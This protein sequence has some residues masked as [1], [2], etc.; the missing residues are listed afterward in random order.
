M[1]FSIGGCIYNNL[2]KVLCFYYYIFCHYK[3]VQNC[4]HKVSKKWLFVLYGITVFS[5]TL[6]KSIEQDCNYNKVVN[7]GVIINTVLLNTPWEKI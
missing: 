5:M 2:C 4:N 7:S 3:S 1:L 6:A